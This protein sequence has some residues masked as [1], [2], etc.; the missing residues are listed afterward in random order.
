MKTS[1]L[2]ATLATFVMFAAVSM[3][4]GAATES[5]PAAAPADAA[6]A[7]AAAQAPSQPTAA[8][9]A[10]P[11]T[12]SDAPP[13]A[14]APSPQAPPSQ[15]ITLSPPRESANKPVVIDDLSAISKDE[16]T[17]LRD[18]F[19]RMVTPKM[20][21]APRTDL[22]AYPIDQFKLIGVLRGLDR[23]RAMLSG[24]NGHT[25]FVSEN[26]RMGNRKGLIRKITETSLIVREKFVNVIGKEENLDI[27]LKLAGDGKT[28]GPKL[29]TAW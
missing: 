27:E 6:P 2:I 18:P 4:T 15:A 7:A 23:P 12:P 20:A 21:E 28:S 25:F 14:Q 24:P 5:P 13:A 10:Q 22:E 19:K 1:L 9:P 26:Q 3:R 29:G 8:R 11:Q 17:R 16:L